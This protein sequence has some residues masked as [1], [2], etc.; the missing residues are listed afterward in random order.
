MP[1]DTPITITRTAGDGTV[2]TWER[3]ADI[4]SGGALPFTS[5]P[6]DT[7]NIN[8]AY[9]VADVVTPYFKGLE[10]VPIGQLAVF[11]KSL[12]YTYYVNEVAFGDDRR[13]E[14]I[15]RV[16]QRLEDQ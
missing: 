15:L 10:N 7:A 9:I 13:R 11:D 6:R 2:T 14:I 3:W 5:A 12:D 1:Y 16:E 4:R 8:F